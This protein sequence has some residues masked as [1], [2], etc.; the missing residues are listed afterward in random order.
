MIELVPRFEVE[1]FSGVQEREMGRNVVAIG[2]IVG[3][4]SP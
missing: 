3:L 4:L 2:I 1:R